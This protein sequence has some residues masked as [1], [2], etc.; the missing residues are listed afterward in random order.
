MKRKFFWI[1]L[2][3]L[4]IGAVLAVTF[5]VLFKNKNTSALAKSINS[6]T[7]S[8]YLH[9]GDDTDYKTIDT[10]LTKIRASLSESEDKEEVKNFQDAYKAY[11][12]VASFFNRE[13]NF[14]A[15]TKYY[16]NNRKSVQSSLSKAQNAVDNFVKQIK[17]NNKIT[18]GDAFWEKLAWT[19]C[20]DHMQSMLKS[21]V[22][23]FNKYAK[24]YQASVA[25][26]LLNN[27]YSDIMFLAL[28][29]LSTRVKKNYNKIAECGNDLLQ[30]VGLYFTKDG[31]TQILNYT[32][33]SKDSTIV[34][35]VLDIKQHGEESASYN[36]FITTMLAV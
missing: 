11:L 4:V 32:Y 8:G 29:N 25:S 21:T 3:L 28:S 33:Q 31:E 16:K 22:D 36:S 18:N 7:T 15:Y 23:A 1:I 9:D 10:Y 12:T 6:Y 26:N 14:M 34:N 5:I 2:I 20:K 27:D 35:T 24:I 17:K 30:F 13:T 19:N